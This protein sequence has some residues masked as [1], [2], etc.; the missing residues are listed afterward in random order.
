MPDRRNL[1]CARVAD[2]AVLEFTPLRKWPA[3]TAV[4]MSSSVTYTVDD[5]HGVDDAA[6]AVCLD[7]IGLAPFSVHVMTYPGPCEYGA[8]H[9]PAVSVVI[10]ATCAIPDYAD[11]CST[12]IS[13]SATCAPD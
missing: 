12:I 7:P 5:G 10:H 6:C 1:I 9:M 2:G 3:D 13:L 11:L 4:I 8:A